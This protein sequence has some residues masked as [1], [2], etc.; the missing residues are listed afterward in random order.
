M[1]LWSYIQYIYIYMVIYIYASLYVTILVAIYF[2]IF[3][4]VS[5]YLDHLDWVK[6]FSHPPK[7]QSYASTDVASY[8]KVG[9]T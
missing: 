7:C 3:L 8:W 2:S 6:A 5:I 9:T 4:R 1:V